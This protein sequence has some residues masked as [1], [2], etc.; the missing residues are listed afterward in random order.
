MKTQQISFRELAA[1][2]KAAQKIAAFHAVLSVI[3]D[4]GCRL[5]V[6]AENICLSVLDDEGQPMFFPSVELALT[7]LAKI[8]GLDHHVTVD[9]I[10]MLPRAMTPNHFSEGTGKVL[11][12]LVGQSRPALTR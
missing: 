5:F 11:S 2:P 3:P 6:H 4:S 9:V 10:S 12:R 1:L 7:E 8:P